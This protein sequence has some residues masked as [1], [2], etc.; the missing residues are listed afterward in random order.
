[1]KIKYFQD[2]AHGWLAVPVTLVY[3]LGIEGKISGYS[4]TDG[5][6]AFL[7]EDRDAALLVNALRAAGEQFEIVESFTNRDSFIRRLPRWR[8][9]IPVQEAA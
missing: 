1:M 8:C 6:R 9:G 3:R 4:Y 7:E 5:D 2:P